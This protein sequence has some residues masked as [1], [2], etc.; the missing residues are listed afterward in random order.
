METLFVSK[1]LRPKENVTYILKY[2]K[3]LFISPNSMS[4]RETGFSKFN[5]EKGY[6]SVL[7]TRRLVQTLSL[8]PG[9]PPEQW[10]VVAG[11][12]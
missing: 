12:L 2:F 7:V 4:Y 1:I 8:M 11:L 9:T 5:Q 3:F 10:S 6:G